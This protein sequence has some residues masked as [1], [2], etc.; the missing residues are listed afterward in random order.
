M[1]KKGD[2]L[3][4]KLRENTKLFRKE[5][6]DLGFK[7]V[8]GE[9]PI[10]PIILGEA[11][12]AQDMAAK[13]LKEGIYVIGFSFP[14]VPEGKARIRVQISASHSQQDIFQV[15]NSFNKVGCEIGVV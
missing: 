1:I 11:N 5:M 10:I 6:S 13:L 9:H 8:A 14:V 4:K 3:R 15:I 7:L 2:S 12:I